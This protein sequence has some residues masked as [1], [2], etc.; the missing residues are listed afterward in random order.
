MNASCAL[1]PVYVA[2]DTSYWVS[3]D[4]YDVAL[5]GT[6]TADGDEV[7]HSVG[8]AEDAIVEGRFVMRV[9]PRDQLDVAAE[10]L[11]EGHL[12]VSHYDQATG[13]VTAATE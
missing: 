6:P 1:A 2:G 11:W 13:R 4:T 9:Y 8:S 7:R 3:G 12:V 5:E 10:L